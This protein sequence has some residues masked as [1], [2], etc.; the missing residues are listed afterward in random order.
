M[1]L[2]TCRCML[3]TGT[4]AAHMMQENRRALTIQNNQSNV[5]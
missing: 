2:A 1:G 5:L 4:A 3:H